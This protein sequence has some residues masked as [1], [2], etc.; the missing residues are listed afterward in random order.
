MV[1]HLQ[2]LSGLDA[3]FLYLETPSQ[4]LHVC[5]VLELDASTIP[6]GYTF[7]RLRDE[8]REGRSLRSAV[9]RGWERAR[10]TVLVADAVS[11]LA[12]M[13]LYLVSIGSVKGFAFTLGLSTVLDLLVVFLFRH[14]IMTM[15]A[16]TK[17]FMSPRVSGLG[18]VLRRAP[19]DVKE[20]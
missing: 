19:T 20:A 16:N 15:F 9:E 4:P 7:E 5:S 14:P 3:S 11:F 1:Q 13:V 8:V 2:R 18:R 12:A 6:G 10:R 17:A